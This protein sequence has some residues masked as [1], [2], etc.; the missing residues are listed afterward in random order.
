MDIVIAFVHILQ[1]DEIACFSR[2]RHSTRPNITARLDGGGLLPLDFLKVSLKPNPS[3]PA[4]LEIMDA[5]LIFNRVWKELED[6]VGRE[7][8]RFPKELILL[9]GALGSGKGTNTDFI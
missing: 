7:I 3:L 2:E 1:R 6:T 5:Q 8:L 4:D 9:G